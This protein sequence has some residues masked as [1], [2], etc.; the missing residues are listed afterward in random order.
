MYNVG[1]KE[2]AGWREA[3]GGVRGG[4]ERGRGERGGGETVNK[5]GRA[6][7]ET[8]RMNP[9]GVNKKNDKKREEKVN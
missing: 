4:G 8:R 6:K 7:C 3:G 9:V 2:E 5:R 1:R